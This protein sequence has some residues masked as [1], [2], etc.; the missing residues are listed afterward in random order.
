MILHE[1]E[2]AVKSKL[3][4]AKRK[5]GASNVTLAVARYLEGKFKAPY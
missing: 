5:L 4:A 3:D 2:M 1:P